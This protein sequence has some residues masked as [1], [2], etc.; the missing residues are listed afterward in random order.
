VITDN[1]KTA[2]VYTSNIARALRVTKNLEAGVIG[3]NAPFLP[4]VNLPIGGV[5]ETG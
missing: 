3:V 5:K 1:P 2:A 4:T